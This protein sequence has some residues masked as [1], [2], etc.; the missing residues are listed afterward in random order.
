MNYENPTIFIYDNSIEIDLYGIENITVIS[1]YYKGKFEGLNTL[2]DGWIMTGTLSSIF[3]FG[4]LIENISKIMDYEGY[5]DILSASMFDK[6][7]KKYDLNIVKEKG[8]YFNTS[9]IYLD[10]DV[11]HYDDY[12]QDDKVLNKDFY[13]SVSLVSNNLNSKPGQLCYSDGSEYTGKYHMHLNATIMSGAYHAMDSEILYRKDKDGNIILH[14]KEMKNIYENN[15]NPNFNLNS[16]FRNT[17]RASSLLKAAMKASDKGKRDLPGAKEINI[18]PIIRDTKA[19]S[20]LQK[21]KDRI[22]KTRSKGY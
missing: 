4:P 17:G 1:F 7:N 22:L 8:S 12:Y 11:G 10:T 18:A 15:N 21:K 5:I 16:Q 20:K 3:C 13:K 14:N 6:Y 2:P 19:I 9:N